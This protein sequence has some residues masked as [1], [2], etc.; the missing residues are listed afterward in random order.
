MVV[1]ATGLLAEELGKLS[2]WQLILVLKDMNL[3]TG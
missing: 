1:M 2:L 3:K